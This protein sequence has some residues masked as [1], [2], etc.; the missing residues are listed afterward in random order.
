MTGNDD[1]NLMKS[2]RY[3]SRYATLNSKFL[4]VKTPCAH[5]GEMTM[6][7]EKTREV[8][9][10]NGM[11]NP[12]PTSKLAKQTPTSLHISHIPILFIDFIQFLF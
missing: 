6:T 8:V 2:T 10:E 12:N 7:E 1:I 4:R 5:L 11:I 3:D 9:I